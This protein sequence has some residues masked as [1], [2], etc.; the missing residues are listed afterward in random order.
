V[1]TAVAGAAVT[2]VGGLAALL[3]RETGSV[4]VVTCNTT[5]VTKMFSA[6]LA[7]VD[8][9]VLVALI[10]FIVSGL[11]LLVLTSVRQRWVDRAYANSLA[12]Y[13]FLSRHIR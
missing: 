5:T 3:L 11:A 13:F 2:V 10:S 6:G 9:I 1:F 4:S 8:T 7:L 12:L